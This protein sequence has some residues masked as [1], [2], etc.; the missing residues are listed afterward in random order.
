VRARVPPLEDDRLLA[1][2]IAAAKGLVSSGAI[3]DAVAA[4]LAPLDL[5]E[6]AR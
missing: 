4:E 1:P 3:A 6:V 2:D 5:E